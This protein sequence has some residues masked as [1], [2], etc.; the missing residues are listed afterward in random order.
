[1]SE[2][3]KPPKPSPESSTAKPAI[4][5]F[6]AA[7][8]VSELGQGE[9]EGAPESEAADQQLQ[10]RLARAA[11]KRGYAATESLRTQSRNS[12]AQVD[13]AIKDREE[14]T[15]ARVK[16]KGKLTQ[17][18]IE[19]REKRTEAEM[20]G[21]ERRDRTTQVERYFWMGVV[22]TGVLGAILLA[23]VTAGQSVWEYRV[24]PAASLMLSGGGGFQLW[25]I[26]RRFADGTQEARGPG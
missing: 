4:V 17:A 10:R 2:R 5:N 11:I 16:R 12:R 1:M 24:S 14:R 26:N 18:K 19:D 13:A 22:A 20:S 8:L 6:L 3:S 9:P 21:L 23:F 15:R 7:W 25:S